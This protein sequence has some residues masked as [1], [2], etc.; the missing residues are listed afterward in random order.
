VGGIQMK[1]HVVAIAAMTIDGKI[2]LHSKHLTDWTSREDKSFLRAVLDDYEVIVLGN[3]TYEV[4]GSVFS[5]RKCIVLTRS[6]RTTEDKHGN[7]TYLNP[8]IS[9]IEGALEPF[10]KVAL[11][12]GTQTY[13]YFLERNLIDELYLTI[14]PVVF[15]KGLDLFDC[16]DDVLIKFRV[17]S[18][19]NLNDTGTILLHYGRRL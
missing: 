14:E 11:L 12:G 2:A 9:S 15:G 8:E 6:G 1:P 19:R 18:V 5:K 13:T 3:N 16:R 7:L 4:A 10:G 17:V